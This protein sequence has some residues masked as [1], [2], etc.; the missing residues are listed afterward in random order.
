M[1]LKIDLFLDANIVN[2]KEYLIQSANIFLP[3]KFVL[4]LFRFSSWQ[5]AAQQLPDLG[6]VLLRYSRPGQALQLGHVDGHLVQH[7]VKLGTPGLVAGRWVDRGGLA[8]RVMASVT[9]ATYTLY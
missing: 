6:P 2:H 1:V 9:Y 4:Y 7:L 8:F 5:V 3:P